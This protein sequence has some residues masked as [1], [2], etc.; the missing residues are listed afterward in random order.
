M[1][2]AP[3]PYDPR[4]IKQQWKDYARAQKQ[5][6]RAR[7]FYWRYYRRPSIAGPILLLTVGV[8]ALL[9]ETGRIQ[10]AHF[11]AWYAQWW[12]LILIGIG[13]ILLMEYFLDRNNPYAGR[14]TF[15]GFGWLIVLVLSTAWGTHASHVW[16][17]L[18]DEFSGNDDFWSMM[19]EEHNND[20][21]ISQSMDPAAS[22]QIQDPRGDVTIT[23]SNDGQAHVRAHQV[24]HASSIDQAQ[25]VFDAVKPKLIVSGTSA[26]LSVEGRNNA[27]VDLTVELPAGATTVVN[28]GHGDVAIAGLKGTS[29]VTSSHGDVKFDNMGGNVHARMDH[30]DFAAHQIAGDVAVD[31]RAGDVTLSEIK[32]N[33]TL[34]GDFFGDTH[35]EQAA[36]AVRFH[37]SRTDLLIPKLAGDMTMDSS[38]L[39]V[40]QAVGP[41]RVIT[42]SKTLDLS[43]ISGDVHVENNN[44]DIVFTAA[45]PLGNVQI[46][47]RTGNI[48]VTLP[49]NTGFSVTASNSD[50]E[51]S[52]D[53]PIT[54][55]GS[56]GHKSALGQIGNGGPR[57][58]LTTSHGDIVLRK[59]GPGE[60]VVSAAPKPPAPPAPPAGPV[61]H[62]HGPRGAN[63]RPSEQ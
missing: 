31:G 41:M 52:T 59:G 50:G 18:S 28:A 49:E 54:V 14:R 48:A 37:S 61:R 3:P 40:N 19:G 29:D 39:S 10:A 20:V 33:I 32:G 57:V 8:L 42:R 53:F 13:C 27:R 5:A 46:I 15:G 30:G 9:I 45:V 21:E 56:D 25:K 11:W 23:A 38:N 47:N 6:A 51:L 2:T 26:V 34:D 60:P 62:L 58:E 7:S 22:I 4:T 1:A 55:N 36:S 35:V 63:E 16:G 44:G 12:P 24:V 17:P 43:Q